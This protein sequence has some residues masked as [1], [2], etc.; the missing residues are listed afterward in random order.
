[1]TTGHRPGSPVTAPREWTGGG[2]SRCAQAVLAPNPSAM[3][4]EGTN[5]WILGEPGG[6]VCVVVDPG[7]DDRAHHAAIHAAVDGRRVEAVLLTHH[8]PDHADGARSYAD[9][10]GTQVRGAA[11]LPDG[12]VID[13]GGLEIG[14]LATP[15]HTADSLCF[16]VGADDALLT[17]DTVL[18]WGTTMVAWPDGR[19]GDYLGSLER[20]GG[21]TGSGAVRRLLP[22]HGSVLTDADAAVHHYLTHRRDRLEQVRRT[23]RDGAR[24][25]EQVVEVVYADVPRELWP[26]ATVS[27]RAQLAHLA[28][29]GEDIDTTAR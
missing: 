7:P 28:D 24:T 16:L 19:L 3:T 17:G 22:G 15:G 18:G 27:V 14:V 23:V 29:Q 20:I 4:L 8:H 1:M 12:S 2:G 26:A 6:S 13:V 21:M 9:L 10:A 11:D 25:P 5:T